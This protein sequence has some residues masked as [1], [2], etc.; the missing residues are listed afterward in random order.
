MPWPAPLPLAG[1]KSRKRTVFGVDKAA[2]MVDG[3]SC[4]VA[5]VAVNLQSRIF[6]VGEAGRAL[7]AVLLGK[8]QLV[9]GDVSRPYNLTIAHLTP[10]N[11]A[12]TAEDHVAFIADELAKR[13]QVVV[14][15]E[16]LGGE[17]WAAAFS[18]ILQGDEISSFQG[19]I[20]MCCSSENHIAQLCCNTRWVL[21]GSLV[22]T[23]HVCQGAKLFDDIYAA[24]QDASMLAMR[25]EVEKLHVAA[26]KPA[27]CVPNLPTRARME[28]W[29]VAAFAA[30]G[31][32]SESDADAD[33]DTEACSESGKIKLLGYLA[34]RTLAGL[35]EFHIERLAVP[36]MLRGQGYGTHL[37]RLAC[38][39]ASAL[40]LSS[41]W[42]YATPDLDLFYERLG[43]I[44]MGFK[45]DFDPEEKDEERYS[46]M[47]L[48][49]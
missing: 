27:K 16:G 2:L 39:Q 33:S 46:W 21:T 4:E 6:A 13:P 34:Y 48:D 14:I 28:G 45:D 41:V 17:T 32:S 29:K 40:G 11:A 44:N 12:D 8:Q 15:D 9:H 24:D 49:V 47:M 31:S 23:E 19:A 10:Q 36:E 38:A 43:F 35:G 3:K 20:V 18:Q 1:L 22:R 37:I 42:L 7:T 25:E 5:K 26:F 30:L